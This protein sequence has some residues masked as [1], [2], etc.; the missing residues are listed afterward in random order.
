MRGGR[1][2]SRRA[3]RAVG[4]PRISRGTMLTG[5]RTE[6][7]VSAP[8]SH[9]SSATSAPVFPIPTTR[10][11][12]PFKSKPFRYSRLCRTRPRKL[13]MPGQRGDDRGAG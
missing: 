4:R 13:D 8:F 10:T 2:L 5:P 6:I 1:R 11:R 12:F 3:V 7:K 9:R